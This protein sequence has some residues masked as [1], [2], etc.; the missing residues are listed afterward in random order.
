MFDTIQWVGNFNPI[1]PW[2]ELERRLSGRH[3]EGGQSPAPASPW[4]GRGAPA[5]LLPRRRVEPSGP[6]YAELH[7]H[8]SFSF[9]DGASPP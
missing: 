7:C 5:T 2:S 9:L 6:S 4:P 1:I 3:G 8:S